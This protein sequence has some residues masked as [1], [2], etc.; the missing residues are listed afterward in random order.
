[1]SNQPKSGVLVTTKTISATLAVLTLLSTLFVGATTINGYAFRIDKLE[2]ERI[3][4][5][6]SIDQLNVRLDELNKQIVSLTIALNRLED[7]YSQ[8]AQRK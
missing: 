6:S 1:M 4:L 5:S 7:R 2:A 3:E 8:L